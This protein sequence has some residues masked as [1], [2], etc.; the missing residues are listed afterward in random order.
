MNP[1]NEFARAW[2]DPRSTRIVLPPID[3]NRILAARYTTAEPFT[4]TRAVL[5][6]AEVHKAWHPDIYIPDVVRQGTAVTW[7]G[8]ADLLTFDRVSEQ[9]RWLK[10][11][12]FGLV[13]ERVHL[14]PA[15]Q[16]ATFIG[17]A[18]L[19][20]PD[21]AMLRA[22]ANQPLFHVEH[23]VAG[24]ETQ[25]LNLW[26][27]VHLTNEPDER[28]LE[29]LSGRVHGEWLPAFVEIYIRAHLNI[30]LIRRDTS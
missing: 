26:R 21:G 12:E 22:G 11:D 25:P 3:V 13:L 8:A 15:R 16:R 28:L 23:A 1:E 14:N 10:P 9:R 7:N 2:A 30:Q 19:P 29:A 5:W 4:L 27:V 17:V 18:E 24:D 6:D 20:G